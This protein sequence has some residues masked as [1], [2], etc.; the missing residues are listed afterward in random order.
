MHGKGTE[1]W[2][3]GT[4]YKGYFTRGKKGPTGELKFGDGN[5]YEGEFHNNM[6]HGKGILTNI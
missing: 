2:Q 1:I 4:M 5:V 3:N 6:L